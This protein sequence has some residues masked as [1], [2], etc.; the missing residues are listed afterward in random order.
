MADSKNGSVTLNTKDLDHYMAYGTWPKN[1]DLSVQSVNAGS[2]LDDRLKELEKRVTQLEEYRVKQDKTIAHIL[3]Q[4]ACDACRSKE[5]KTQQDLGIG[6]AKAVPSTATQQATQPAEPKPS[7]SQ[8]A[9]VEQSNGVVTHVKDLVSA[10]VWDKIM[11]I[12]SD[13]AK[14]GGWGGP[15]HIAI[16]Y[17]CIKPLTGEAV[18]M[19]AQ[20]EFFLIGA[21]IKILE[22]TA[23]GSYLWRPEQSNGASTP[24]ENGMVV[25]WDDAKV[26]EWFA[27]N[28]CAVTEMRPPPQK[29]KRCGKRVY[30]LGF[31][32]EHFKV[33]EA[34][35]KADKKSH[36]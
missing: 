21:N 6:G 1:E 26:A 19:C 30:Q 8:P 29:P 34:K 20:D 18:T 15:D 32:K 5:A 22:I 23:N 14:M 25:D 36:T 17:T 10:D 31:C 11:Q 4:L 13:Q 2:I 35:K 12:K 3:D 16:K 33:H 7:S 27:K 24:S 28:G 9:K